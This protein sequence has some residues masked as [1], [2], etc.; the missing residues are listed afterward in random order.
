MLQQRLGGPLS[1]DDLEVDDEEPQGP[2]QADQEEVQA[3]PEPLHQARNYCLNNSEEID[4]FFAGL[5]DQVDEEIGEILPL[6]PLS[7]NVS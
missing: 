5:M 6:M 4:Q 3:A 2:M 1:Q 7:S